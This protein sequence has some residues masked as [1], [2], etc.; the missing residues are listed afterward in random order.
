M[1]VHSYTLQHAVALPLVA[2]FALTRCP[3]LPFHSTWQDFK[4]YIR[5]A[6]DVDYVMIFPK[7]TSGWVRVLKRENFERAVGTLAH[8]SRG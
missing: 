7:S 4:D 2:I 1:C 3:Q 5:Q 6:A 8:S